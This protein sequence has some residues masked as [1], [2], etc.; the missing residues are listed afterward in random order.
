MTT[1]FT[2]ATDLICALGAGPCAPQLP[3]GAADH[4]DILL[5]AVKRKL[6]EKELN[7]EAVEEEEDV[8]VEHDVEEEEAVGEEDVKEEDVEKED[9]V[10]E[11]QDIEEKDDVDLFLGLT[12]RAT[13]LP[14]WVM[15]SF[16]TLDMATWGR[17]FW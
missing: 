7:G 5:S 13:R 3:L 10:E 11:E 4:V 9:D 14:F 12:Y 1:C 6:G 15:R 8:E 17:V 2:S 16:L